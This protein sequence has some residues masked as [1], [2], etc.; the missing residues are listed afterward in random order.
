[1]ENNRN[2][3]KNEFQKSNSVGKLSNQSAIITLKAGKQQ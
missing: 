1:M 3:I 2:K